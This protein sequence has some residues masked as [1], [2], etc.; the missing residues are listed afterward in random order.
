[1]RKQLTLI[2]A[3]LVLP[4]DAEAQVRA[5][6][7]A[8]VSQ[9]IDGT[10]IT[11]VYSRPR[12]RGRVQLFGTKAVH[13]NE[14]WT[15]GANSSTTLDVNRNIKLNGHAVRAGKYSVWFVVHQKGDWTMVLDT[16]ALRYHTNR[17]DTNH[18]A[19]R[20]P[21]RA[22]PAPFTEVLT[23]SFP[24]VGAKDGVLAFQWGSRKVV[25]EIAVEPSLNAST[26]PAEAHPYVGRYTFA[27][28]GSAKPRDFV[29]TLDRDTLKAAW[30]PTDVGDG[31]QGLLVKYMGRFA[32]IRVGP[33]WFVPG[34]YNK[35]GEIYEVLRPEMVFEFERENG[36]I[37]SF[38]IRNSKDSLW[39]KA[40]RKD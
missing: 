9:T 32:L 37:R 35:K 25:V 21:V 20:F 22:R 18:A 36:R 14:V 2:F 15:P 39:A 24:G 29:I 11:M 26:P 13:W 30:D 10:K 5:S 31:M 27:N 4:G 1:M 23:W 33:D 28:T 38:E 19:V 6:E 8:S 34:L 17:P 12:A 3:L 16:N 7:I 40:T